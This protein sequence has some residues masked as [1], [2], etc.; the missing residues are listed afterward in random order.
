MLAN[1][2]K[3]IIQTV[4]AKEDCVRFGKYFQQVKCMYMCKLFCLFPLFFF[5]GTHDIHALI[6]GRAITGL[7]SFTVEK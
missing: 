1:Y 6:L 5:I 4:I 2:F 7:Q 3:T